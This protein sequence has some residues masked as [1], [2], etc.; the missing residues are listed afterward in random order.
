M[1]LFD[2]LQPQALD[3]IMAGFLAFGADPRPSKINLGVGMYYDEAGRI[4]VMDVVQAAEA[5]VAPR[6][7]SWSY[8]QP[9]GLP[10]LREATKLLVFGSALVES[11]GGRI[12]TDQSVEQ[13]ERVLPGDD[14][15]PAG[16]LGVGL[17][18]SPRAQV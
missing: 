15:P 4:P 10:A 16:E 9:D 6:I 13:C 5:V 12:A 7:T 2:A 14:L 3:P 18:H 1:S 11:D 8:L 17:V